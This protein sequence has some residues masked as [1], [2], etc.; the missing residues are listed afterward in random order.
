MLSF[1]KQIFDYWFNITVLLHC[2]DKH[3]VN[4]LPSVPLLV[5]GQQSS[6][7]KIQY[8]TVSQPLLCPLAK[9]LFLSITNMSKFYLIPL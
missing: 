8:P 1:A 3:N 2:R 9:L 5:K 7:K 4:L 6:R